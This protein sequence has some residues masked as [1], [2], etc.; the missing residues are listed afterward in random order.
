MMHYPY[1]TVEPVDY[2]MIDMPPPSTTVFRK[3]SQSKNH[4]GGHQRNYTALNTNTILSHRLETPFE[5]SLIPPP[6]YQQ[7]YNQQQSVRVRDR[8]QGNLS[9]ITNPLMK[10]DDSAEY[11]PSH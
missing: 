3:R 9:M 5:G 2:Q 1:Q 8:R 7:I 10:F 11:I 6:S 4:H